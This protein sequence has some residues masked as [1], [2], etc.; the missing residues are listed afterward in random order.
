MRQ[1]RSTILIILV[2]L[3][4]IGV[5]YYLYRTDRL[6]K[7][8]FLRLAAFSIPVPTVNQTKLLTYRSPGY[9]G[10]RLK[11][12]ADK[13]TE[14]ITEHIDN[15]NNPQL[16][17]YENITLW[18]SNIYLEGSDIIISR[19]H[20]FNPITN[21]TYKTLSEYDEKTKL[22]KPTKVNFYD[23]WDSGDYINASG[24]HQRDVYLLR[25]DYIWLIQEIST[26][27]TQTKYLD[28]I[29]PTFTLFIYNPDS[30][31]LYKDLDR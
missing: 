5:I 3:L 9:I 18:Q 11:F 26:D 7:S 15:A 16:S 1:K 27:G 13:K 23:G 30:S 31:G 2:T 25:G 6:N 14:D 20:N 19:K 22:F 4:I 21:S 12:P 17:Q 29:L 24:K 8:S 10:F 28:I